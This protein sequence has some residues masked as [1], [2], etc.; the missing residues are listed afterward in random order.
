MIPDK[1]FV[2]GTLLKGLGHPLAKRLQGESDFLGEGC[3]RGRLFDLG[4]YPA[5]VLDKK[6]ETKVKGEVYRLHHPK[7]TLFWLDA[8][9]G[10]GEGEPEPWE[11]ERKPVSVC[12]KRQAHWMDC[13][14]YLY[15]L[16][17]DGLFCIPNGDYYTFKRG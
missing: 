14:V 9:E 4:E 6:G 8:Y 11:Y 3:F 17:H 7:Q 12:L 15:A 16:A 1:L 5:A 13:W 10:T 2:Y